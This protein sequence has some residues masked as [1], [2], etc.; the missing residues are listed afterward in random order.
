[1]EFVARLAPR[2]FQSRQPYPGRVG[3]VT[4][5]DALFATGFE[6]TPTIDAHLESKAH[7][8]GWK[9]SEELGHPI[10]ALSAGLVVGL[11]IVF[12]STRVRRTAGPS[13][14]ESIRTRS[15]IFEAPSQW[16][17][18]LAYPVPFLRRAR[19]TRSLLISTVFVVFASGSLG[20]TWVA[21][22]PDAD[23]VRIAA[24]EPLDG[25]T[26]VGTTK[27]RTKLRIGIFVRSDAK[28]AKEL[29]TLARNDAPELGGN[30]IVA[31]GPIDSD[32]MQRFSIY[33]CP[34]TSDSTP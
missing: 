10:P 21:L 7:R 22:A 9:M 20:C 11:G 5:L 2:L 15:S 23:H 28:V 8:A 24:S 14:S 30:T 18:K 26:R 13:Q 27:A 3:N 17:T 29:E 4:N 32:G 12:A 31:D 34:V 16:G 19:V 25:C 33:D 6:R 1:M